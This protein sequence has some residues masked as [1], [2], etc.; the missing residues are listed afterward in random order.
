[1]SEQ[2][3]KHRAKERKKVTGKQVLKKE[4]TTREKKNIAEYT[5]SLHQL[6][7][8]FTRCEFD[9]KNVCESAFHDWIFS[10]LC[11][12]FLLWRRFLNKHISLFLLIKRDQNTKLER[13]GGGG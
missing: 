2:V 6:R 8:L 9:L 12:S 11:F 7:T 13:E 5:Y 10:C 4:K 3:K 1:M